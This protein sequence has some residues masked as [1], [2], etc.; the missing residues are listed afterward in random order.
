MS[1]GKGIYAGIA[2]MSSAGTS[3]RAFRTSNLRFLLVPRIFQHLLSFMVV[4][5]FTLTPRT[6]YRPKPLS[7]HRPFADHVAAPSL[8]LVRGALGSA[9]IAC[10]FVHA[11]PG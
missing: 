1:V 4:R 9:R 11:P 5:R 7:Y 6:S 2:M 8:V 10:S 3:Q